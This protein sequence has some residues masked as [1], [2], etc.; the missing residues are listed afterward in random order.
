MSTPSS[1]DRNRKRDGLLMSECIADLVVHP[2]LPAMLP[3]GGKL[4]HWLSA[5]TR[6][7]KP[8]PLRLMCLPNQNS[9]CLP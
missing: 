9:L 8:E 2:A 4:E 3:H 7:Q 6:M 5:V 1:A